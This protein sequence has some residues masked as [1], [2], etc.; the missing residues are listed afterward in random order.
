MHI[1]LTNDDGIEAPGI[2]AA[3]RALA[4]LGR[5]TIVAPDRERSANSHALTIR[6]PLYRTDH[7]STDRRVRRIALSGTPVDCV[8]MAL[9]HLLA[10]D[11]PDVIVSGINNGYN[12]GSD[13]IYSGT[14]AAAMEGGFYG[15]PA[16]AVSMPR[17]DEQ[18]AE[19]TAL[20]VRQ[21]IESIVAAQGFS[22]VLNINVPPRGEISFANA[23]VV[24]QGIQKYNNVIA[25]KIDEKGMT[26]YWL[27]GEIDGRCGT[28]REDV[29]AIRNQ[30]VTLT[31]LRW[32]QTDHGQLDILK[33]YVRKAKQET[34]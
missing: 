29:G 2:A 19:E 8:K 28:D 27:A 9:D 23:V 6:S 33:K 21:C 3:A 34:C 1:L 11:L 10:E 26:S 22:G 5:V 31:P 7:G 15:I 14:V 17:F 16:I 24:P 25:E 20:F 13:V 30:V 18:R 4:Q 12:L 32:I